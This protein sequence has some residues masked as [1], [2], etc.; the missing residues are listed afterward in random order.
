MKDEAHNRQEEGRFEAIKRVEQETVDP[1]ATPAPKAPEK[2]PPQKVKIEQ[3]VFQ[4]RTLEGSMKLKSEDHIKGLVEA[5][6][7]SPAHEIEPILIWWSGLRWIVVDGH[8]RLRAY[9]Q[10]RADPKRP[11]HEVCVPVE[12]FEGDFYAALGQSGE[13]NTKD[14]LP[15]PKEGKSDMAWRYT[16]LGFDVK[17]PWTK[18]HIAKIS[19]RGPDTITNTRR[20]R[21]NLIAKIEAGEITDVTVAGLMEL[22]WEDARR[23]EIGEGLR[24]WDE[25]RLDKAAAAGAHKLRQAFKNGPSKNPCSLNLGG[26]IAVTWRRGSGKHGRKQMRR[27]MIFPSR[28]AGEGRWRTY[29]QPYLT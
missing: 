10:V 4:Q 8:H 19:G 21:R 27:R 23:L 24:S 26:M 6:R 28:V 11:I 14:K 25:E 3:K 9:K 2:L 20:V 1:A 18:A 29:P 5:I 12:V 7:C 13:G 22:S 16:C 15:I 17:P